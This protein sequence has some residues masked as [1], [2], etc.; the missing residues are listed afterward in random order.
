MIMNKEIFKMKPYL[1]DIDKLEP[2]SFVV[3]DHKETILT[4]L[5]VSSTAE[6]QHA[7]AINIEKEEIKHE[8][9]ENV[10]I[11]YVTLERKSIESLMKSK[12]S[13]KV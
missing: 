10:F 13:G 5:S 8:L 4:S 12:P 6:A 9:E 1:I 2:T 11:N 7:E 3:K